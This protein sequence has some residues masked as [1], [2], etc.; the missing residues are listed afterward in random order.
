MY[1]KLRLGGIYLNNIITH[2]NY[3]KRFNKYLQQ[4]ALWLVQHTWDF[5]I[6]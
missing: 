6:S 2:R 4:M 5:R 1:I 3:F